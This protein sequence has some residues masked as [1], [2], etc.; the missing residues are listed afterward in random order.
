MF[1]ED[2][3]KDLEICIFYVENTYFT[4][5]S[6]VPKVYPVIGAWFCVQRACFPVR[7]YVFFKY[8]NHISN[9]HIFHHF[10]DFRTVFAHFISLPTTLDFI[11]FQPFSRCSTHHCQAS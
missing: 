11:K 6:P 5:I 4:R 3:G 7:N 10:S 8:F 1:L 2:F 9:D